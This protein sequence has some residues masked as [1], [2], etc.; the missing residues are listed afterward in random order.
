M[1]NRTRKALQGVRTTKGY[2][3]RRARSVGDPDSV[4]SRS[5]A[6]GVLMRI[7]PY[8]AVTTRRWVDMVRVDAALTHPHPLVGNV[9]VAYVGGLRAALARPR[10]PVE[11]VVDAARKNLDPEYAPTILGAISEVR[12]DISEPTKGWCLY[13]LWCAF[14]ALERSTAIA[15]REALDEVIMMGGDTDT[16][17]AIAGGPLGAYHGHGAWA[18]GDLLIVLN[19]DTNSGEI[20]RAGGGAWDQRDIPTVAAALDAMTHL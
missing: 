17:A 16:N 15:P 3:K 8:A 5:Q 11:R 7:S 14:W 20:P 2:L 9:C 10:V 1:G 13:A 12:R 4:V 19:C 6:N 18:G